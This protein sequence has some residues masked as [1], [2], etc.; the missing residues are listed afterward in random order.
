MNGSCT[1]KFIGQACC[2]RIVLWLLLQASSDIAITHILSYVV[3]FPQ[4]L[5]QVLLTLQAI[6]G[7]DWLKDLLKQGQVFIREGHLL[8]KATL[9]LHLREVLLHELLHLIHHVVV[10]LLFDRTLI[11]IQLSSEQVSLRGLVFYRFQFDLLVNGEDL[12]CDW[13]NEG[14]VVDLIRV[15]EPYIVKVISNK[16]RWHLQQLNLADF[17]QVKANF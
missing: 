8:M 9:S 10:S 11:W 4:E 3:F 17:L 16:L 7:F 6:V 13:W 1:L 12:V 2:R 15:N 5:C 14:P